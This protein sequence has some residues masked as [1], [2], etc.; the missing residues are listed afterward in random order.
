MRAL[1]GC[2]AVQVP[3]NKPSPV[4]LVGGANTRSYVTSYQMPMVF[5]VPPVT[6]DIKPGNE[7][8][9]LDVDVRV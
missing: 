4:V 9:G 3:P 7:S 2:P 8:E 5:E 6:I 1:F